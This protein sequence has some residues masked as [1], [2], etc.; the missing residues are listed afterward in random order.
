VSLGTAGHS[1]P[2]QRLRI[3]F[4]V[5]QL[6]LGGAERQAV[7]IAKRLAARGHH[8]TF[9]SFYGKRLLEPEL[10]RSGIE[11][12]RLDAGRSYW[13]GVWR[14]SR[15]LQNG[16]FDVVNSYM[17]LASSFCRLSARLAGVPSVSVEQLPGD[18]YPFHV[19]LA[20]DVSLNLVDAV[21]CSS[22]E[23]RRTLRRGTNWYLRTRPS[24]VIHNTID[25]E[26]LEAER[27]ERTPTRRG[28]GIAEDDVVF[29]NV[30]RFVPQK[31]LDVLIDAFPRIVEGEPRAR[32]LLVGWGPMREEL[33][34]RASALGVADRVVVCLERPDAPA[35]IAASDAFLFPSHYEGFGIALAEA[36][37]LGVPVA[38]SRVPPLN[39][40]VR[41]GVDG[42]LVDPGDPEALAQAALVL[43]HDP[44]LRARMVASA[45]ARVRELFEVNG[46]AL[47]YERVLAAVA[48]RAPLDGGLRRA[49]VAG[50]EARGRSQE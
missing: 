41:D 18:R 7:D 12:V 42:L 15:E 34:G 21:I 36:M 48:Q 2:T 45:R 40:I 29:T 50:S 22:R 35:I 23:V 27:G 20:N 25:L 49:G 47:A 11:L 28:L 17:A 43:A 26:R 31:G 3:A 37:A 32:L 24:V 33:A 10:L 44:V 4:V 46:A 14:L 19:R 9:F 16:K 30:G 39:E 8:C 13:R 38:A 1:A 5:N 6:A